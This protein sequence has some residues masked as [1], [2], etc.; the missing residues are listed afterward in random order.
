MCGIF[1]VINTKEIIDESRVIAARDVLAHRGPDDAGIYIS[2]CHPEPVEGSPFVVLAHR[3]LSIIDLSPA[4]HQPMT[5]NDG[6]FTIVY[7]GEIYNYKGLIPNP[8]PKEKGVF[9]SNSDTEVIL[10][11]YAKYGKDCLN[12]LRG[13][14]AFAIWDEQEKTLFA[15]RDRFGIKPFYYLVNDDEFI[16]SSELKAIKHY[17]GNLKTNYKAL[18]AFLRTGSVPA[19]LTI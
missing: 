11:L 4:G 7:N 16:F 12:M 3:R 1:G 17:K 10:H 8:S 6:R 15:A 9:K 18:D 14:F 19:P 13:M 2:P 5:T